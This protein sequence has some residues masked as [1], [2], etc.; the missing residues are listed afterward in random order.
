MSHIVFSNFS[1][2]VIVRTL[3]FGCLDA[4]CL[5]GLFGIF[6]LGVRCFHL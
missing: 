3:V 2:F 4:V 5:G 1:I 6:N